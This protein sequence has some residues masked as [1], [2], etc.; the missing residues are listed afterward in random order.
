[1]IWQRNRVSWF[2]TLRRAIGRDGVRALT[3]LGCCSLLGCATPTPIPAR[4]RPFSFE[5]DTFAFANEL[6]WEYQFDAETGEASHS[7]RVPSP[8][9]HHHCFVVARSARQFFAHARF[10]PNL[11]RVAP[12]IYRELI[13][14]PK[15][16]RRKRAAEGKV[17]RKGGS[18]AE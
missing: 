15:E 2:D 14:D 5:Q 8:E 9:Y 6:A 4:A 1:M 10:D 3:L 17:T 11:P 7:P 18:T 12:E 16:V 13:A